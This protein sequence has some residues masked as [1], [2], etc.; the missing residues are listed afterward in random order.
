MRTLNAGTLAKH[1]GASCLVPALAWKLCAEIQP[2]KCSRCQTAPE[3]QGYFQP[4]AV[5]C[6]GSPQ[7]CTGSCQCR[8]G[9]SSKA[10]TSGPGRG[11]HQ[12]LLGA[13]GCPWHGWVSG[14]TLLKECGG[15]GS[16]PPHCNTLVSS[17]EPAG[18]QGLARSVGEV[19]LGTQDR[20]KVSYLTWGPSTAWFGSY[21]HKL[22][23]SSHFPKCCKLC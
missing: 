18:E 12:H 23:L 14:R 13:C 22:L 8:G 15:T 9:S 10:G 11:G 19:S 3:K 21:Q 4:G 7:P 16:L 20:P 2:G 17:T 6:A 1:N 5:P